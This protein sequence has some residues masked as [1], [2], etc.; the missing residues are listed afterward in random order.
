MPALGGTDGG[1]LY[2]GESAPG[3]IPRAF[4]CELAP[5]TDN[6]HSG[7]AWSRDGNEV[8]YSVYVN[9]ERPQRIMVVR[10]EGGVWGSP[11]VAAFSGTYQEGGPIFSVDGERMYFYSKRPLPGYT[12]ENEDYDI[13]FV[14]RAGEGWGGAEHLG[15]PINSEH[16]DTVEGFDNSGDMVLSRYIDRQMCLYRSRP[17]ADGWSEPELMKRVVEGEVFFQPTDMGDRDFFIFTMNKQSWNGWYYAS[18]FISYRGSDGE[19]TAPKSMGDM[20]NRGEGRFPSF[21][22]DGRYMFF[23]SYRTGRAAHYWLDAGVIDYLR[24]HDLDLVSRL[25]EIVRTEGVVAARERGT[26]WRAEHGGYYE[27]DERLF[28]DVADALAGSGAGELAV[29]VFRLND[30]PYPQA[31]S[32]LRRVKIAALTLDAGAMSL[33]RDELAGQEGCGE[34]SLNSLGRVYIQGGYLRGAIMLFEMN[35][36]EH[37]RSADAFAGLAAAYHE[38]GDTEEAHRNL[39]LALAIDPENARAIRVRDALTGE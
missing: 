7:L 35:L 32:V 38:L 18:L 22:S 17:E 19:W 14:E 34:D 27:F 25:T 15:A 4:G 29:E 30:E 37:P 24:E 20:I 13:W 3:R 5:E 36:E 1:G 9:Y 2:I 16:R 28:D 6:L 23:V 33:L 39:N 12:E 8:Y 31:G 11:G 21:S 26:A 10:R